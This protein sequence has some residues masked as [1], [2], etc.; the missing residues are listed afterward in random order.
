M[1]DRQSF[2]E[3][4]SDHLL[5]K[6]GF[7]DGDLLVPILK[8]NGF[9]LIDTDDD[10][11][12]CFSRLVLCEVVERFVC[13]QIENQIKPYRCLTTHNPARVYEIDGTHI[14]DISVDTLMLQPHEITVSHETILM[15]AQ[16]LY[17]VKDDFRDGNG[18]WSYVIP[19]EFTKKV[20]AEKGWDI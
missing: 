2:I 18:E 6:W 14:S 1:G 8:E 10:F 13:T 4:Q 15:T 3:F 7:A 20:R 19:S 9:P 11:W 16:E 17:R 12:F 5:S